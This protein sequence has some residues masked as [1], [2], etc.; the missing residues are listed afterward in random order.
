MAVLDPIS[1]RPEHVAEEKHLVD[2]EEKIKNV[3]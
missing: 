2:V 3:K 1:L